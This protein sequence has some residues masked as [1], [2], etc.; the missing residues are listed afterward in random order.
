ALNAADGDDEARRPDQGDAARQAWRSR[1]DRRRSGARWIEAPRM[2]QQDHVRRR[3]HH[4]PNR[5]IAMKH[6]PFTGGLIALALVAT[7]WAAQ[8]PPPRGSVA[9]LE[10][11]AKKPTP[12]LATGRTD[13]NGTWDHLGGIEFVRP[14]KRAD[15]SI[16]LIACG[17]TTAGA[18]PAPLPPGQTD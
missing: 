2:D 6:V 15:G 7:T 12:R 13:F 16:C 8:A 11:L 9:Q 1:H 4:L 5:S 10:A 14:Q 17:P 3:P 18:P